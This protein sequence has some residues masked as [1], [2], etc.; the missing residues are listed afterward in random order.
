MNNRNLDTTAW[1]KTFRPL[2]IVS[3][4]ELEEFG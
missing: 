3:E 2:Q 4:E 1:Q